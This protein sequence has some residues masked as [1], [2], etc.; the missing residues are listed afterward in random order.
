MIYIYIDHATIYFH[1]R[2]SMNRK[3]EYAT[4]KICNLSGNEGNSYIV[5]VKIGIYWSSG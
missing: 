5:V 1:S 4:D 2:Y 3:Y